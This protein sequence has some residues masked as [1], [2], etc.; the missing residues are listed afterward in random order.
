MKKF[1]SKL[2]FAVFGLYFVPAALYCLYNNL[3]YVCLRIFDPTTYLLLL[4]LRIGI[5]GLIFQ[6]HQF[7]L[8]LLP[9]AITCSLQFLFQQ[10]LSR[11][12]WMAIMLL[13]LGCIVKQVDF[14]QLGSS[15]FTLSS[16]VVLIFVF[17]IEYSLHSRP[18]FHPFHLNA[19]RCCARRSRVSIMST[20]SRYHFCC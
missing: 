4:Q 16:G 1:S 12:Q 20:C 10:Q 11:N 5:T 14:S 13:M 17:E 19:G 2:P 15:A 3:A 7:C 18:L 8:L 6:V 9:A